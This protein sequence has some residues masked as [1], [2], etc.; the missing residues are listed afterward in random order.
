MNQPLF[1]IKYGD[2]KKYDMF[3]VFINEE[4]KKYGLKH[5]TQS[6][7]LF[8]SGFTSDEIVSRIKQ[9]VYKKELEL[10]D[11]VYDQYK[12]LKDHI[13]IKEYFNDIINAVQK[14]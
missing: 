13:D 10:S 11:Y 12:Y 3:T 5:S 7:E 8:E 2:N 4:S 9:S 1:E 6:I 14:E